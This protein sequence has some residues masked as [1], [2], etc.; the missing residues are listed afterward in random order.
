MSLIDDLLGPRVQHVVDDGEG[1]QWEVSVRPRRHG[2]PVVRSTV[3]SFSRPG[4]R[5]GFGCQVWGLRLAARSGEWRDPIAESSLKLT[6]Q[7]A[8]NALAWIDGIE[9][10]GQG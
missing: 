1:G 4:Q 2:A 7:A 3:V 9:R 8:Q 10:N 6:H 5:G